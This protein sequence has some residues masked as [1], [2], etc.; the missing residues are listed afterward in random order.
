VSPDGVVDLAGNV[1]EWT[2]SR[3]TASSEDDTLRITRGGNWSITSADLV[4]Y[5]GLENRKVATY[6]DFTIGFRCAATAANRAGTQGSS[7]GP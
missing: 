4:D 2:D 1:Q 5:M 7:A 6:E 3:Y